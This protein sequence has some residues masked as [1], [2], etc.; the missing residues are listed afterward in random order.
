MIRI[1]RNKEDDQQ[2]EISLT[3]NEE[4][5]SIRVGKSQEEPVPEE[6][7]EEVEQDEYLKD[8]GE[9]NDDPREMKPLTPMEYYKWLRLRI[10][11]QRLF[12]RQRAKVKKGRLTTSA[13]GPGGG[14]SGGGGTPTPGSG[15]SGGG[16]IGGKG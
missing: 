12:D 3:L 2:P 8:Q 11:R 1:G 10:L 9:P 15:G 6:I 4:G 16:Q 5:L 7:D 14:G 13:P